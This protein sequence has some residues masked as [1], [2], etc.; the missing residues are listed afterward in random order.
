VVLVVAGA[1]AP[2][3]GA[4]EREVDAVRRLVDAG[5]RPRTAAGIVAELSGGRANELYSAVLE[6]REDGG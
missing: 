4:G 2:V 3:G 1:P 5:A 6:P